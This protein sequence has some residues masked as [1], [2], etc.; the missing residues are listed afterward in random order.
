MQWTRGIVS[1]GMMKKKEVSRRGG[2]SPR[3]GKWSITRTGHEAD[4]KHCPHGDDGK[5]EASSRGELTPR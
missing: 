1:P 5:K 4:A 3:P 2:L